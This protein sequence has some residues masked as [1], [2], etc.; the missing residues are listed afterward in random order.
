MHAATSA[1]GIGSPLA[2]GARAP[3]HFRLGHPVLEQLRGQ[4]DEV[5]QH[6]VPDSRS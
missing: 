1:S 2:S 5:A 6:L 3:H 4:L